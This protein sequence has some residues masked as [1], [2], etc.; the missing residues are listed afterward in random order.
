M[1]P[2]RPGVLFMQKH[3]DVMRT[4][5]AGDNWTRSQRQPADRLRVCD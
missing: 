4:D 3:W 5:D 2:S 1:N